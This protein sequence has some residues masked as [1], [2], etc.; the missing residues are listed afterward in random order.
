MLTI[1]MINNSLPSFPFKGA[2]TLH[3][4]INVNDEEQIWNL[5][6][7]LIFKEANQM[8][9]EGGHGLSD[10]FSR[11]NTLRPN[12][13]KVRF[14]LD[15][16]RIADIKAVEKARRMVREGGFGLRD[17]ALVLHEFIPELISILPEEVR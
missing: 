8:V 1:R 2:A 4:P 13:R 3:S 15:S 6:E 9:W 7:V 12:R 5:N 17:I 16:L 14:D 10:V 11:L